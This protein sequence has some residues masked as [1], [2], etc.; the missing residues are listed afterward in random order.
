MYKSSLTIAIFVILFSKQIL[1]SQQ[2]LENRVSS[3]LDNTTVQWLDG[4]L[5]SLNDYR[6]G[7]PLYLKFWASWCQPCR[8]QMPHL[9][10]TY[11]K[12]GSKLKMLALNINV[13]ESIDKITDTRKEF[14]LTVPIA[15]D[16]KGELSHGFKLMGT[17]YHV[18]IAKDGKILYKGHKLSKKLDDTIAL[19]TKDTK[20]TVSGVEPGQLTEVSSVAEVDNVNRV[21]LFTSTWCDDYFKDSRP[22]MSKN[23][24]KAQYAVNNLFSQFPDYQWRG[25]ISRMWTGETELNDYKAKYSIRHPVEIDLSNQLYRKYNINTFPTLVV[26]KQGNEVFRTTNFNDL[27]NIRQALKSK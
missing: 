16:M 20:I 26:L 15:I 10:N 7:K 12:Y 11:E 1:A 6:E 22:E 3:V 4:K 23:C 24:I 9:Q 19:L 2:T 13:N 8:Q 14:S 21:L 17:P 25:I 18:L 5:T 27:T